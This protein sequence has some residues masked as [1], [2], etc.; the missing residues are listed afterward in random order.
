LSFSELLAA[1]TAV[2]WHGVLPLGIAGIVVWGLWLYRAI[3]SRFAGPIVNDFRTS[4]SVVVPSYREDPD[5]LVHCLGTWL[6]QGPDEVIIVLDVDDT[7]CEAQL[8]AV[9][10]PRLKVITF[11]HEGKRSALGVGIRAARGEIVVLSDSDTIWT[12]GLPSR[13]CTSVTP[14]SG[15]AWRTGW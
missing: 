8:A 5:I 11:K 9:E 4:V 14:A 13:T 10:D 15:A 7:D 1:F 3:A 12:D 6:A 2:S